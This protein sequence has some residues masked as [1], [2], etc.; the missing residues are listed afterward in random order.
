MQRRQ[1]IKLIYTMKMLNVKGKIEEI[2][3][4]GIVDR[5]HLHAVVKGTAETKEVAFSEPESVKG[6]PPKKK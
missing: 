1:L 3:L 5:S 6:T 2:R 4:N